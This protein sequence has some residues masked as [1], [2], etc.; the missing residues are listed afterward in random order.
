MLGVALGKNIGN[1][2]AKINKK[3]LDTVFM[4]KNKNPFSQLNG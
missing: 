1:Y 2:S 3:V 4:V